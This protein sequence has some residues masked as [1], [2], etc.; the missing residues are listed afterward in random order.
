VRM[1]TEFI[2]LRTVPSGG[3]QR[4]QLHKLW[5]I[6]LSLSLCDCLSDY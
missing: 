4:T 5:R 6:W 1:W 3:L 2:W